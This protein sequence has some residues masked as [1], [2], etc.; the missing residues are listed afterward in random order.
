MET[1][2]EKTETR[3]ETGKEPREATVETSQEEVKATDLEAN[4][5]AT[6]AVVEGQNVC[7]EEMNMDTIGALE[8]R[9]GDR[10]LAVRYCQQ[11]KKRP[12][13][14][15]GPNRSLPSSEDG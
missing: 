3:T 5:E 8:D 12:R 11:P 1:C 10:L 14:V 6:E 13:A 2:I 7:N 15:V 4:Q 9:Y